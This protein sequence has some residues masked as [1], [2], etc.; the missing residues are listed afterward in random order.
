MI[1]FC[2]AF[3]G[4]ENLYKTL[5]N[6]SSLCFEQSLLCF[7]LFLSF[8]IEDHVLMNLAATIIHEDGTPRAALKKRRSE[9][10]Q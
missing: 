1:W 3:S 10:K 5:V 2:N 4:G 6:C 9:S 7:T 8:E